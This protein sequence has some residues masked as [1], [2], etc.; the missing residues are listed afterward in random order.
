MKQTVYT[1]P[2]KLNQLSVQNVSEESYT[3]LGAIFK[4]ISITWPDIINF[5]AIMFLKVNL[6]KNVLG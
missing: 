4:V 1:L 6:I 5:K 3:S 2:Q